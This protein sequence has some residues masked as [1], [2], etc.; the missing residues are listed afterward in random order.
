[1]SDKECARVERIKYKRWYLGSGYEI[2]FIRLKTGQRVKVEY[3]TGYELPSSILREKVEE[4]V[5]KT[6]QKM[7]EHEKHNV[8][9]CQL[10]GSII[11][12][13]EDEPK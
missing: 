9:C 8:I 11:C 2:K 4:F 1:M 3:E 5:R 13:L 7:N 6:L 12:P 10:K